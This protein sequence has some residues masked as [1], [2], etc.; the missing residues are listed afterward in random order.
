MKAKATWGPSTFYSTAPFRR[1][2]KAAPFEVRKLTSTPTLI[3]ARLTKFIIE[4]PL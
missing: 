3:I 1:R 2:V 4:L